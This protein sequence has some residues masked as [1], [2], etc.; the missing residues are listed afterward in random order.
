MPTSPLP[1][2]KEVGLCH[3]NALSRLCMEGT[4]CT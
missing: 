1:A 4:P 2:K 3:S